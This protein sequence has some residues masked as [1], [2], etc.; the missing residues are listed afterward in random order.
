MISSVAGALGSRDARREP[1]HE[2]VGRLTGPGVVERADA[3][4]V[5]R[6]VALRG[7]GER[8]GRDLARAVR[9]HR[10]ERRGLA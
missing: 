10:L 9:G 1:R 8:L 5:D 6:P 3:D 4:H 2:E 7:E